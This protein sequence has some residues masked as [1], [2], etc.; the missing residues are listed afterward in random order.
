[1]KDQDETGRFPCSEG[2]LRFDQKLEM[3]TC[4]GLAETLGAGVP[5]VGSA[6]RGPMKWSAL[7]TQDHHQRTVYERVMC[8]GFQLRG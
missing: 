8:K 7:F 2:S 1:M 4:R 3:S 5:N 6:C